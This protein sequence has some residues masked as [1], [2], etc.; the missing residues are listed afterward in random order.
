MNRSPATFLHAA[1]WLV[2]LGASACG[3]AGEEPRARVC[4]GVS[5][6]PEST[7]DAR[8]LDREPSI[9]TRPEQI[10]SARSLVPDNIDLFRTDLFPAATTPVPPPPASA[11][12]A[13]VYLELERTLSRRDGPSSEIV[14][15]GIDLFCSSD[16]IEKIAE[17][18]LRAALAS[19]VGTSGEPAASE[20][21]SNDFFTSVRF[22]ELDRADALAGVRV[23]SGEIVVSSRLELEDFRAVAPTLTHEAG[24]RDRLS[25]GPEELVLNLASAKVWSELLLEEPDLAQQGTSLVRIENTILLAAL[26]AAISAEQGK[27]TMDVVSFPGSEAF[28]GNF[29]LSFLADGNE[30]PGG[31]LARHYVQVLTMDSEQAKTAVDYDLRTVAILDLLL[32]PWTDEELAQLAEILSLRPAQGD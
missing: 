29:F 31:T 8:D 14:Q 10:A 18:R 17:H 2:A 22:G 9:Q 4:A 27:L 5:I 16:A 11:D 26:N 21:L 23:R 24:H 32:K 30:S 15:R 28:A 7:N 1:L 19:L 12:L 3:S 20:I 13:D 25:D 6:P